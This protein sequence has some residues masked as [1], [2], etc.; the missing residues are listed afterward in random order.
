MQN[1]LFMSLLPMQVGCLPTC[2]FSLKKLKNSKTKNE[3][4]FIKTKRNKSKLSGPREFSLGFRISIVKT[5]FLIP[6]V[7]IK[8]TTRSIN[9]SQLLACSYAPASSTAKDRS[10]ARAL[11]RISKA[12][13]SPGETS[14]FFTEPPEPCSQSFPFSF[15]RSRYRER[16]YKS[17]GASCRA[18]NLANKE[19]NRVRGFIVASIQ[20]HS[21][22][23]V[24]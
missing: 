4:K 21:F 1:I 6:G 23:A 12:A 19:I 17:K 11:A 16:V 14:P 13:S 2:L 3:Y 24:H 7:R 8:T 15:L 22:A 9:P 20:P 10:A 18:P 5:A